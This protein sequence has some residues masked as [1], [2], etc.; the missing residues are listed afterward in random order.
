M[1]RALSVQSVKSVVKKLGA[2]VGES[3][4]GTGDEYKLMNECRGRSHLSGDSAVRSPFVLIARPC[5][6]AMRRPSRLCHD[7]LAE[8]GH[9]VSKRSQPINGIELAQNTLTG[10][11]GKFEFATLIRGPLPLSFTFSK[12]FTKPQSWLN[13]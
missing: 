3:A 1:E 13:S 6:N 7:E 9:D 5:P 4:N 8:V 2:V 11:S 10:S 12:T